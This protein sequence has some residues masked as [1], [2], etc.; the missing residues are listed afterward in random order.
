MC[1]FEFNFEC[2]YYCEKFL[3]ASHYFFFP[4]LYVRI[5]NT[6]QIKLTTIDAFYLT[7]LS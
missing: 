5:E 3:I 2:I 1:D 6:Y 7:I 4:Y